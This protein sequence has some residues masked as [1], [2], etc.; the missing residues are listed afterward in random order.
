[1][2]S[3]WGRRLGAAAVCLMLSIGILAASPGG[4]GATP[5]VTARGRAVRIPGFPHTG[6][7]LGAGAAVRAEVKIAGTEYGGYPPP[8]IGISV[9]LPAG[10]KLH[11]QDF[12]TCPTTVIVEERAPERCPHGSAAGPIGRVYGVVAFGDTRVN[13]TAELFSFFAPGGGLE[14]LTGG[15]TP[16]SIEVPTTAQMLYPNGRDGFGPE[17]TGPIPLVET[18]PGGPDASVEAIDVTLGA[19]RRRHGKAVYYGTVPSRCPHG[20]FKA[21]ATFT[22]AENG[23]IST[24][25]TVAVPV[26]APCPAK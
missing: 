15:H 23:N 10:V 5:T 17:F 3:A 20:G 26:I 12:P 2:A 11:P 16:A 6:D 7:I 9:D 25:V 14:F 21:K 19:A 18:V 1:M 8:L 24:P 13:E 22:F 4:A